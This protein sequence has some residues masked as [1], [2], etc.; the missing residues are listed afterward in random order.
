MLKFKAIYIGVGI[1]N[2][3]LLGTVAVQSLET[4]V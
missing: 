1:H 4:M 3:Y 2:Q